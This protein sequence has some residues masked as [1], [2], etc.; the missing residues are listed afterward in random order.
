MSSYYTSSAR[1]CNP[2]PT[3]PANANASSK[4]DTYAHGDSFS[5]YT[6]P[7][8]EIEGYVA[9]GSKDDESGTNP[10]ATVILTESS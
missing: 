4:Y 2:H 10:E 9:T 7:V 1:S 5:L 6:G 8:Q 3:A